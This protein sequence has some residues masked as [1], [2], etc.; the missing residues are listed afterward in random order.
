MSRYLVIFI[1]PLLYLLSFLSFFY[2]TRYPFILIIVSVLNILV[3]WHFATRA[4]FWQSKLPLLSL[5]LAY[6]AQFIFLILLISGPV[7]YGLTFLLAFIWAVVWRL[8]GRHYLDRDR[9]VAVDYL[10]SLK[11][12]YY[13]NFWFLA[14]SFYALIVLI[15][16]PAWLAICLLGLIAGIWFYHIFRGEDQKDW[17]QSL[18]ILLILVPVFWALYLIPISFFVSGTVA[19]LWIFFLTDKNIA[20]FRYFPWYVAIFLFSILVL[21]FTSLV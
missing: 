15:R 11:F 20:N 7:R 2:Y 19:T 12:F 1:S 17:R 4:S 13:L 16:W 21:L 8:L 18:V 10:S 14:S 9:P 5:I 6:A 3:S